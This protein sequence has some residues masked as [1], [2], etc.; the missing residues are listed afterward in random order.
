MVGVTEGKVS[1]YDH[2]YR[3]FCSGNS[4][5]YRQY[6]QFPYGRSRSIKCLPN[7]T[8]NIIR[9]LKVVYQAFVQSTRCNII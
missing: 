4:A 6:L 3:K 7:K 2:A 9:V 1:G 8:P 5:L